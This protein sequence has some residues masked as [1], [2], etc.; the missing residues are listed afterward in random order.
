MPCAKVAC[1]QHQR[2]PLSPNHP[3]PP[4]PSPLIKHPHPGRR[5][6]RALPPLPPLPSTP[7]FLFIQW[8]IL[9]MRK[10][11]WL[12]MGIPANKKVKGKL[13]LNASCYLGLSWQKKKGRRTRAL[14][15][16]ASLRFY[17]NI[18]TSQGVT[19][20]PLNSF[21]LGALSTHRQLRASPSTKHFVLLLKDMHHYP[22]NKWQ[23]V[24][25][26]LPIYNEW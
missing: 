13:C 21:S 19:P 1:C 5:L 16:S 20:G 15:W 2:Y 24:S 3:T 4:G 10:K 14:L 8:A 22:S 25:S 12:I 6:I 18:I 9:E 7:L 23:L 11:S 26:D 17:T